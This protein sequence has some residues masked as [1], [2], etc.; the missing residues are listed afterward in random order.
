[1][2]RLL[3]AVAALA[4]FASSSFAQ[5]APADLNFQQSP[6][7]PRPEWLKVVDHGSYDARLKGYLA[8]EG[9]K[10]E[11]VAQ[12]P[13]ILNPVGMTFGPDGT[14]YVLEWVPVPE[15]QQKEAAVE[16]EFKDGTKKKV[17]IMRKPVKDRI[18]VLTASKEGGPYDQA[19]V[20]LEDEL[21]SSILV[22]DGWLYTASQGTVRRWKLDSIGT[23]N[24]KKEIIARGFCGFHHHQ[25]SGL[26]IGNDGWLY[27]TA[28]DD[29]NWAEGSDGSRAIVPRTG[30]VFRC[31]PDGSNLHVH[32]IGYR[33]PYRDVVFDAGFNMFHVD[34]DNEDGSKF[35]GCRL[36]HVPEGVDFGWRLRPG[37]RCCVPDNTRAAVYGE[38]PGKVA[39]MLKTGRGS[40]A[41]LLLYDETFLP[42][43]YRGLLFYPDVFRRLIRAYRVEQDGATFQ[44]AEEFEF[45]KSNDPLFRPC[46]MVTGPDGAIYV[47][48]WRTD[49]GGAGRLWGDGKHGRILRITWAGTKDQPAIAPRGKDAWAKL[50]KESDEELF[51]SLDDESLID[52]KLVT[53]EL[54]RRGE[55]SRAGF[56]KVLADADRTVRARTHAIAG[57]QQ[58]WND[59]VRKA[60]ID[61]VGDQIAD[62]RRTA[63]EALSLHVK[64][65]ANAHEALVAGL[66]ERD[67]L[68]LRQF[69]IALGKN[70][71][72]GAGEV[73]A[74]AL[75]NDRGKDAYLRDGI[76]R[77]IEYSGKEAFDA[78]LV[79]TDSGQQEDTDRVADAWLAFRTKAAADRIPTLVQNVNLSGA[80]KASLI[81]SYSNY[82]LDPPI[83]VKPV[84]DLLKSLPAIEKDDPKAA[85]KIAEQTPVKLAAIEILASHGAANS[86]QPRTMLVGMLSEKDLTVRMS[87][88]KAIDDSKTT[89]AAT[90]LADRLEMAENTAEKIAI[91]KTLG[92]LQ[93]KKVAAKLEAAFAAKDLDAKVRLELFRSLV[94]LEAKRM[95]KPAEAILAEKDADPE[96]VREAVIV[97]VQQSVEGARKVGRLFVEKQLPR[98][99]LPE[100]ADGLRKHANDAECAKLLSDAMKGGLLLSSNAA[101]VARIEKL[102]KTEGNADRG[103]ALFLNNKALAC[104]TCH[105][106]EGVGGNIGPDLTRVWETHSLEKTIESMLDPSKEIK[107]GYQ[108]F[109]ATTKSGKSV[110]GL[111]V[112][113]SADGVTLRDAT[114]KEVMIPTNDLDELNP[115]KKSLMPDDVVKHLSYREFLDLVAFLRDRQ[116]Q[117]SLRPMATKKE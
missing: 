82:Q 59:D 100:V 23:P 50:A 97:A 116:A 70:N 26:T 93:D 99:L 57:A 20:L 21:P 86:D 72:P 117:E 107:E 60:M 5:Q 16:F 1:M 8:P 32:S 81:R 68:V 98:T 74:N 103:K 42:E 111:R 6:T 18:K 4:A 58:F 54:V 29:D 67:R 55:K 46:Q 39:P 79:V 65:D 44:V 52:R 95:A 76:L 106:L 73:L 35:T 14:L 17:A 66:G 38:L 53:Q 7:K 56:L 115:T 27:I 104:I 96:L 49:S 41:G 9:L 94:A 85:E 101:E 110:T 31:M 22:H 28:G 10:I 108:T 75:T 33:N 51:R 11:I 88:I 45:L 80:Q 15:G 109:V 62:L 63:A 3:A 102:L 91:A 90:V 84:S 89:Q 114:G 24:E 40:P 34:N 105:K 61:R 83:D 64:K 48:D 78:L 36:M 69:Y 12:E 77:A 19:K 25:V 71:A 43:Q 92:R 113:Q 30:G 112:S 87:V 2:V 37:A 13:T 47:C